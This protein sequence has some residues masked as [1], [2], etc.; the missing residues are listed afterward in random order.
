MFNINMFGCGIRYW[1]CKIPVKAFSQFEKLH[2]KYNE[3]YESLFFD[4]DVLNKLGY[5]GWSDIYNIH[6]GRGF[7]IRERNRIEIKYKTKRLK[8]FD[9]SNLLYTPLMFEP[10]NLVNNKTVLNLSKEFKLVALIQLETGSFFRFKINEPEF[11]INKLTFHLN[12]ETLAKY[13][14][15]EFITHLTYDGVLLEQ[16]KE[17]VVCTGNRV[18]FL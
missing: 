3:D 14:K 11:D 1:I 12:Y 17:D 2:Q 9:S 5:S 8:G 6:E 7:V 10:Y 16:K 15:E 4:L 18:V 13:F